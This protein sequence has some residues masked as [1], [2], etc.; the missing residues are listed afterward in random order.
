MERS[1]ALGLLERITGHW[2]ITLPAARQQA[3]LD[4]LASMDEGAAGTTL[5]RL[6]ARGGGTAPSPADFMA[7][8]ATLVVQDG[9]TRPPRC[10]TC[11]GTGWVT[12]TDHPAHWPGSSP[13]PTGPDG[14]CWCNVSTWCR[15]C[16]DGQVARDTMARIDA[17][18]R[19]R[20]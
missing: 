5:A 20:A 10:A 13:A 12:S 11:G 19:R 16:P 3:W 4:M 15:S 1:A 14:E 7:V 8:H 17:E 18:R 2:A 9:G 6:K